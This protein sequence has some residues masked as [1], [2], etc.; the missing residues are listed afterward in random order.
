MLE[1]EAAALCRIKADLAS[2]GTGA[3][4]EEAVPEGL[5]ALHAFAR[6]N[7]VYDG[8]EE[9][10]LAGTG[11]TIY[12]GDIG[13]Y[14]LGSTKHGGTCQPFYPTWMA[15]ARIISGM[16]KRLG[17]A[18]VVDVGSGDGRI[19]YCAAAA[20]LGAHSVEIDPDLAGLQGR[21]FGATGSPVTVHCADAL[22]AD[23]GA[24]GLSRPLF[25]VGALPQMGGDILASG[26]IGAARGTG[27]PAGILLAGS[28]ESRG[29][30]AGGGDG[31][32]SGVLGSHGLRPD[33]AVH[34][35][36]YWTHDR[37]HDTPYIH[38]SLAT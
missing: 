14:W 16:A 32:W 15:S 7:P 24:M 25:V 36:T 23:Y 5:G 30:A 37:Q 9:A 27:A 6:A 18:E 38:A 35:P 4:L 20:G 12:R 28:L 10:V 33:P 19:A 2:R 34:L 1:D 21:I 8:S 29:L 17:Y 11:C 22:S 3:H 31:G 26:V 13:G